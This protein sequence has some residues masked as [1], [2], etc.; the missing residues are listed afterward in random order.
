MIQTN[1]VAAA[2]L[3]ALATPDAALATVY[4]TIQVN[5]DRQVSGRLSAG[6]SQSWRLYLERGRYYAVWGGADADAID[7]DVRAAGGRELGHAIISTETSYDGAS[8][9][10][11]YSGIYTV[12]VTCRKANAPGCAGSYT[13]SAGR[14]CPND[15]STACGI[16]VG[17]TL[18][19]LQM[20]FFQDG[21]YFRTT[22][23]GGVS[24]AIGVVGSTGPDEQASVRDALGR[25]LASA[26]CVNDRRPCLVFT[27]PASGRYYVSVSAFSDPVP[28][29]DLSLSASRIGPSR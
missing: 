3:V 11:P 10:A 21:D 2:A 29:Y 12:A 17:Q 1:T 6:R 13:L 14:D 25:P 16:A 20:R 28:T 24:Y 7:L 27:A 5:P 22:L 9:R 19:D 26:V 4:G 23:E 8:F 15:T 18:H